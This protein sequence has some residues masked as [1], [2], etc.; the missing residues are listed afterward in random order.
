MHRRAGSMETMVYSN[1][2][3]ETIFR[4]QI[5]SPELVFGRAARVGWPL[6]S[7]RHVGLGR[8]ASQFGC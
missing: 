7:E 2:K 3:N 5:H 8:W 6:A 1:E 4:K